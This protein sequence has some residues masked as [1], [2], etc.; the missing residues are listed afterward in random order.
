[1]QGGIQQAVGAHGTVGRIA[2][3]ETPRGVIVWRPPGGS[4]CYSQVTPLQL[5]SGPC[6]VADLMPLPPIHSIAMKLATG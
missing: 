2:E 4:L 5:R 1:M 6:E 3:M